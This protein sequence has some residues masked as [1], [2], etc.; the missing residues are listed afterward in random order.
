MRT[1]FLSGS[2][3]VATAVAASFGATDVAAQQVL[4]QIFF[5]MA[6]LADGLAI[7]AQA[8]VADASGR[9]DGWTIATRISRRLLWWGLW[10]GLLLALAI[11]ATRTPIATIFGSDA[12]VTDAV[13]STLVIVAITQPLA[14]ILFVA[15][16]IY[17]GLLRVKWLAVS[18]LFGAAA[19]GAGLWLTVRSDWGLSGIWWAIAAQLVARAVILAAA[20][21]RRAT[22]QAVS[23]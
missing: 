16:G 8:M 19:T 11:L 23:E 9:A 12:T 17:L 21:P 10:V 4:L 2:L 14:T 7:A 20:Y 22:G 15:D 6:M 3:T 5:L 13:A 1:L 18:T